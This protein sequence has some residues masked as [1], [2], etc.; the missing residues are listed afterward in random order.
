MRLI[1]KVDDSNQ[2]IIYF[3]DGRRLNTKPRPNNDIIPSLKN[4]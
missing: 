4:G 1:F 2:V 3:A